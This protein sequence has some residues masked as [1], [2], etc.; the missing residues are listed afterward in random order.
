M[1]HADVVG[2]HAFD[3]ARHFLNSAKRIL[4]LSYESLVGGLIGVS[5]RGSTVLVSMSNVAIEPYMVDAALML[6]SVKTGSE[7]LKRKHAGR[8]IIGGVDIG[9]R[10]SCASLKLLAY[11]RLLHD[12]PSW[13]SQARRFAGPVQVHG[14]NMSMMPKKWRMLCS[15]PICGRENSAHMFA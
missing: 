9:Q 14:A 8:T 12:Y 11:E 7:A 6:P 4:G 3:H 2:F 15:A 1:L 10:L 5:F 13:Q